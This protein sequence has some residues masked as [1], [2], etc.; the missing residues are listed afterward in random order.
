M[1]DLLVTVQSWSLWS[2]MGLVKRAG[3][4]LDSYIDTLEIIFWQDS[5]NVCLSHISQEWFES[6]GYILKCGLQIDPI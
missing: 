3:Y 1:S 2:G 5:A 6:M 4:T